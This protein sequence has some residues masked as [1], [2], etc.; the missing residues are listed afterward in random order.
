MT[1]RIQELMA[2]ADTQLQEFADRNRDGGGR[3]ATGDVPA[4]AGDFVAAH[5]KKRKKRLVGGALTAAE[6]RTP[7]AVPGQ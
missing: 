2:A 1:E 7:R 6:A 4:T 3:Y 5:A